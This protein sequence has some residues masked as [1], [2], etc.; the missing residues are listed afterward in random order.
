M[1]RRNVQTDS[2]E[3]AIKRV[4]RVIEENPGISVSELSKKLRINR[5]TLYDYIYQLQDNGRI[6]SVK[7]WRNRHVALIG[8]MP[9]HLGSQEDEVLKQEI[10]EDEEEIS[11]ALSEPDIE[12]EEEFVMPPR[13]A[14]FRVLEIKDQQRK[15][16]EDAGVWSSWKSLEDE[17]K[18]IV[19]SM[20]NG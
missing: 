9:E 4:L 7:I 1:S 18:A 17:A 12:D 5:N 11:A 14:L 10:Q 6:D 8:Q 19:K 15:L 3:R 16:L 20:P 13:Q 2:K